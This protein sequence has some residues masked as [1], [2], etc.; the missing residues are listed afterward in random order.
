MKKKQIIITN[1]I[2][3]PILPKC[4]LKFT[5]N[6]YNGFDNIWLKTDLTVFYS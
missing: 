2:L 1:D 4:Q 3:L 5:I 6:N